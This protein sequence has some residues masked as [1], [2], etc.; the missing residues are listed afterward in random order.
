MQNEQ[1]SGTPTLLRHLI[2]FG[3]LTNHPHSFNARLALPFEGRSEAYAH[4]FSGDGL[5]HAL[6]R[7]AC[8][9]AGLLGPWQSLRGTMPWGCGIDR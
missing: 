2:S 7:N 6:R 8:H 4:I 9:G 3:G 5:H 1:N